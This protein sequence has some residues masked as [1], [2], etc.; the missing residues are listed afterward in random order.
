MVT[1]PAATDATPSYSLRFEGEDE[2]LVLSPGDYVLLPSHCRHRVEWTEEQ[3][4]W[5]AL[6]YRDD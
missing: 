4:I 5:L 1:V 2:L 6:H 3:T